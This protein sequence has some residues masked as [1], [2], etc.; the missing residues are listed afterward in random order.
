LDEKL[1]KHQANEEG[2]NEYRTRKRGPVPCF[3][4]VSGRHN[5]LMPGVFLISISGLAGDWWVARGI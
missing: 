5:R 4:I 1:V 2:R 3:P